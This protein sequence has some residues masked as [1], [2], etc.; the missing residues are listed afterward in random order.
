MQWIVSLIIHATCPIALM[1][2]KIEWVANGHCNSNTKFQAQ[3]QNTIFFHSG[4]FIVLV[5]YIYIYGNSIILVIDHQPLMFLIGSQENWPSG[6]LSCRSLILKLCIKLGKLI[7]IL[8]IWVKI[9]VP[10]KEMPLE[11]TSMEMLISRS[12]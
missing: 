4:S 6:N 3:L 10:T 7:V 11:L 9:E 8:T 5:I 1:G 2:V 12:Y